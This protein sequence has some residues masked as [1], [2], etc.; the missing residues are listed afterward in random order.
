MRTKCAD[1]GKKKR[2]HA[3]GYCYECYQAR[4]RKP[5]SRGICIDPECKNRGYIVEL[6]ARNLC[7]DCYSRNHKSGTLGR[8][9]LLKGASPVGPALNQ[10]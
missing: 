6:F 1:C 7:R 3:H 2:H 8:Y 5:R 4:H 9:P 10:L